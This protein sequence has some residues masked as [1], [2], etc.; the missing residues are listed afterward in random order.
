MLRAGGYNTGTY[1]S[2]H[3][4]SVAE[5][6]VVG[7]GK[8]SDDGVASDCHGA[9]LVGW[10]N[11]HPVLKRKSAWVQRLKLKYDKVLSSFTSN[12]NLRPYA[13]GVVDPAVAEII[14]RA[15]AEEDGALT[16]FEVLTALAFM[17]FKKCA[18]DAAVVEVGVGGARDATNVFPPESLAA[19]VITAIG[20]DQLHAL[21]GSLSHVVYA[22]AGIV[23]PHRPVFL[24]PQPSL[25][26]EAG[27]VSRTTTRP[28][29]CSDEPSPP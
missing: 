26:A 24:A 22:K 6:I 9:A 11:L 21:G 16:Y 29:L 25:D 27:G 15:Q 20:R 12:V 1:K 3:V 17:R 14:R 19:A 18:V 13:L 28:M 4:H 2:P 5:R 8:R 7:P 23:R 10:C